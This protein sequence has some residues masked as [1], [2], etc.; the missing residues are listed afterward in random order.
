MSGSMSSTASAPITAVALVPYEVWIVSPPSVQTMTL[1]R[2]RVSMRSGI[3]PLVFSSF[4][5]GPGENDSSIL[6]FVPAVITL[7]GTKHRR[8]RRHGSCRRPAAGHAIH[9]RVREVADGHGSAP[10]RIGTHAESRTGP[11][12]AP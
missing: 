6:R 8:G 11:R 12:H 2:M 4:S 5:S 3:P 10:D 9:G 1:S 7:Q